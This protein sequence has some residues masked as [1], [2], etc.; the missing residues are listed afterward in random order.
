MAWLKVMSDEP[1]GR[2]SGAAR[3]FVAGYSAR[4]AAQISALSGRPD[5]SEFRALR[6]M[7]IR[8][9]AEQKRMAVRHR[10]E[11]SASR[12]ASATAEE[13][14][15]LG[16]RQMDSVDELATTHHAEH[17]QFSVTAHT[18]IFSTNT[19]YYAK[20]RA[21]HAAANRHAAATVAAA[22]RRHRDRRR[23]AAVH[24][25]QCI[26]G[27]MARRFVA[28][29]A[30]ELGDGLRRR[31]VVAITIQRCYRGH[32]VRRRIREAL[33]NAKYVDDDD[34]DYGGVDMSFIPSYGAPPA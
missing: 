21:R 18:A 2:M 3:G 1:I 16:E 10:R 19:P 20:R 14:L 33:D 9:S 11:M 28:T 12:A 8:H 7:S 31:M 27:F 32:R 6:W 17:E 4:R 26:R 23:A 5:G 29:H 22:M 15:Q 24:V 13:Q 30:D 25:Q 34:Y